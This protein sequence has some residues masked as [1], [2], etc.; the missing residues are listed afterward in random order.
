MTHEDLYEEFKNSYEAE[1]DQFIGDLINWSGSQQNK[2]IHIALRSY[3]GDSLI[4]RDLNEIK[5]FI[6]NDIKTVVEI[7]EY[8]NSGVLIG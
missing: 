7:E 3:F 8:T 2:Q 5:T 4:D 6:F 1:Y